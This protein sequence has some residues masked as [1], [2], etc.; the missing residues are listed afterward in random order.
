MR[1][2][3]NR[4]SEFGTSSERHALLVA[5]LRAGFWIV[6]AAS[7]AFAVADL[8]MAPH[9]AELL[10][11]K[12]VQCGAVIAGLIALRQ[13]ASTARVRWI[14]AAVVCAVYATSVLSAVLRGEIVATAFLL[15]GTAMATATFVPWGALPQLATVLAAAA[16]LYA[17]RAFLPSTDLQRA[18]R[19]TAVGIALA[20]SVWIAREHERTRRERWRAERQAAEESRVSAALARVGEEM[21]RS[22]STPALLDVLCRLTVELLDCEHAD[23]V[24]REPH[25]DVLLL[26]SSYGHAEGEL[27]V[28]RN[29]HLPSR[30]IAPLLETF[31][32]QDVV[33]FQTR[34]MPASLIRRLHEE[35]GV[36]SSLFLPLRRAGEVI[37]ILS[38]HLRDDTRCFDPIAERIASGIAH[39]ASMTLENARL[40]AELR[41][42]NQVKSEF[43]STM[44]H[45]LRTPLSVILGYA[46]LLGED[47]PTDERA[48]ILDRLR[49]SGLELLELV[50]ETLNLSRLEAGQDPPR[51]EAVDVRE[52][53]D[54][55]ASEF[56]AMVPPAQAALRW[57]G[58]D[59][60]VIVTDRRKLRTILKNL[61]GNALKFTP[62]GEVVLKCESETEGD[63]AA[64]RATVRDTGIGIAPEH[65]PIIFDM[66]RQ[67]DSSD[68]RSYRGAGL[69]L[70][71][72]Q[73]LV[74]QLGGE[75]HVASELGRG[76]S[77]TFSLPRPEA[78]SLA[79]GTA[80]GGGAPCMSRT[81][82]A[83]ASEEGG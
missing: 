39:L 22:E 13:R 33:Q 65:L 40:V 82:A 20:G 15:V 75:I 30:T 56:G 10:V 46:D 43:V 31:G 60:L 21:I 62:R 35:Y 48:T 16:S 71:I 38:A 66:F 78:P 37:G 59:E 68:A 64:L 57:R 58:P 77:F 67:A 73:R 27:D 24:I 23:L 50:E 47:L 18:Y 41:E 8:V 2:G 63:G 11:V 54:E 72:V 69:G 49:L 28:L 32:T 52:L 70:H 55:L 19:T 29:L 79:A 14:G 61:L 36:T 26:Q 7:I 25:G 42:A 12:L 9:L 1:D 17:G 45:E 83:G 81:G 51:F 76:S 4:L 44:S 53:F 34:E 6:L 5:R 74:H 3:G 80:A